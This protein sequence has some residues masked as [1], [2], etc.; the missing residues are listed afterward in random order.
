MFTARSGLDTLIIDSGESMLGKN[1]HLENFPGFP[2]GIPPE[3][4]LELLHNQA[5]RA[6]CAFA[7]AEVVDLDRHPDSGL[8]VKTAESGRWDHRADRVIAA[9]AETTE[10]FSEIDVATAEENG[11]VFLETDGNGRTSY[12]GLYAAGRLAGKELQAV[13][14]AGHGAEVATTIVDDAGV[15]LAHDWIASAGHFADRGAEIP[16]GRGAI[17]E[18]Q[19][20]ERRERS[21]ELLREYFVQDAGGSA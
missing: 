9:T 14:T 7:E 1:A 8:V 3:L 19:R 18:E 11:A 5:E 4:L 12:D 20:T 15:P 2:L 16:P 6:G 17:T 13:I 10:Y 21:L